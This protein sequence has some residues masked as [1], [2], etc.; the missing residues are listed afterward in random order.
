MSQHGVNQ[1]I[2]AEPVL[3]QPKRLKRRHVFA[4][5]VTHLYSHGGNKRDQGLAAR[6][7]LQIVDDGRFNS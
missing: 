7:C 1:L 6:R 3:G 5:Q 2:I 4:Q